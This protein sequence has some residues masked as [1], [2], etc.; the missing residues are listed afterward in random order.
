MTEVSKPGWI[1]HLCALSSMCNGFLR[2]TSGVTPADL[3]AACMAAEPFQSMYMQIMYPQ[4]L[5]GVQTHNPS[6]P[7]HNVL[8][9]S[10][11]A[12]QLEIKVLLNDLSASQE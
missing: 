4:A 9:Y 7:Q 1:P 5:V 12:A 6:V 11:T 10:A 3:L 2:F 8:H